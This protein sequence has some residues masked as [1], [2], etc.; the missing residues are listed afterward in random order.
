L[1]NNLKKE[2]NFM[3]YENHYASKGVA[4]AGLGLGI[5]GTALGLMAG[6]LGN[7]GILSGNNKNVPSEDHCVNRYEANQ[8]ARIA[9]LETEVKLRD[10]N[11]YTDGKILDLYKY[12]DG[13][14]ACIENQ[15][16]EQRVYNATNTS[17]IAC[18]QGQVAQLAG[19]TKV[20]IPNTS[21]CPG[22]GNV[23]VAPATTTTGA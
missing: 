21:I 8:A 3:E 19:L 9:E 20:V 1:P 5:A 17:A 22:W 13:K 23:T 15:L 12:V 6:G 18:L 7:F 16:C 4:G 10:S 14:L 11:I 2:H